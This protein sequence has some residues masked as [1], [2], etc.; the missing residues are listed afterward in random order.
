MKQSV[1]K[2]RSHAGRRVSAFVGAL[3]LLAGVLIIPLSAA[4]YEESEVTL[5]DPSEWKAFDY[6]Y[7]TDSGPYLDGLPMRTINLEPLVEAPLYTAANPFTFTLTDF[8]VEW[9]SDPAQWTYVS[10]ELAIFEDG[11]HWT[12]GFWERTGGSGSREVVY[13][14]AFYNA[15]IGSDEIRLFEFVLPA[16]ETTAPEIFAEYWTENDPSSGTSTFCRVFFGTANDMYDY[17]YTFKIDQPFKIRVKTEYAGVTYKQTVGDAFPQSSSYS[18][19]YDAGYDAAY[20]EYYNSRYQAGYE[21]GESE[22][23]REM[24]QYYEAAGGQSVFPLGD[25]STFANFFVDKGWT[26]CADQGALTL[27][28]IFGALEAPLNV[29]LGGMNFTVFGINLAET[30]FAVFSLIVIF[31]IVRIVLAILPLV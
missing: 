27:K 8:S 15:Q 21:A 1:K 4:E 29:I 14:F 19:G 20:G 30:I 22:Y 18:V 9:S 3:L 10:I 25:F 31:A 24:M 2:K 16:I 13:H 11:S 26:E 17:S 28:I 12:V 23:H 6:I 7:G 5:G